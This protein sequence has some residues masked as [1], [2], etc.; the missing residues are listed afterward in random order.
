MQLLQ[1]L[2]LALGRG[3]RV[4]ERYRE[5]LQR[6]PGVADHAERVGEVAPDLVRVHVYLHDL[7][8][9]GEHRS[10]EAGADGE[11]DVVVLE[12]VPE[13]VAAGLQGAHAEVVGLR[14]GPLAL[15]GRHDRRLQMLGDAHERVRCAGG[16]DAAPG[17]DDGVLRVSQGARG[18][19]DLVVG[20]GVASVVPRF[21]QV[22][23]RNF[24]ERFGRYLDLHRPGT[25]GAELAERFV[26]RAAGTSAAL[27]TR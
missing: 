11:E 9:V 25:P 5:L 10:G 1:H 16:E 19:F 7:R 12:V 6:T 4:R 2:T 20:C 3:H 14:D 8:V 23:V 27:S 21:E 24:R 15:V 22:Y 13:C 17:P 26:D 18:A